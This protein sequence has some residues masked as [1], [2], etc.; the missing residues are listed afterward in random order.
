[1]AGWLPTPL[2]LAPY[3]CAGYSTSGTSASMRPASHSLRMAVAMKE[4]PIESSCSSNSSMVQSDGTSGG[5][6][7]CPEERTCHSSLP[8]TQCTACSWHERSLPL[9][10][11][12]SVLELLQPGAGCRGSI[13]LPPPARGEALGC[14]RQDGQPGLVQLV[15]LHH[16]LVLL[17][18]THQRKGHPKGAYLCLLKPWH[19][20]LSPVLAPEFPS[21][22]VLP[23]AADIEGPTTWL[24][25]HAARN[26]ALRSNLLCS[27]VHCPS[28]NMRMSL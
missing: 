15:L 1:M 4:Q 17:C 21:L 9:A 14:E 19:A 11:Q 5:P 16:R 25:L 18:T 28:P 3:P 2:L 24:C 10:G 26:S 12:G 22:T 8:L 6:G 23:S 27:L 7:S 20:S 13:R